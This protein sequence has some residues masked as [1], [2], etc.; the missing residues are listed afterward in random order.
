MCPRPHD[1]FRKKL[2]KDFGRCSEDRGGGLCTRQWI[3]FDD[4]QNSPSLF[5][6]RSGIDDGAHG[7]GGPALTADHFAD[8][9]LRYVQLQHH[10]L[11]G[12]DLGDRYL[13]RVIHQ[14]LRDIRHQILH[15][16]IRLSLCHA[17]SKST[18]DCAKGIV[19]VQK[20]STH[21]HLPLR[22]EAKT[23][24]TL[25]PPVTLLSTKERVFGIGLI[26]Y[27]MRNENVFAN[28]KTQ[29]QPHDNFLAKKS[30]HH[31]LSF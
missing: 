20:N 31:V 23:R 1:C 5:F 26:L 30:S 9:R 29:H 19:W 12:G 4:F 13:F 16:T 24:Q 28:H 14:T 6:R 22:S 15:R 21:L 18:P 8:I 17:A 11:T 27:S 25:P 2:A 10:G 3:L 7:L